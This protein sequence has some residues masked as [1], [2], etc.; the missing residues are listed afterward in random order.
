MEDQQSVSF[1]VRYPENSSRLLALLAVFFWFKILLLIPHMIILYALSIAVFFT[2]YIAQW[3][4]LFTG[5]YPRGLFDFGVGV[6]RWGLRVGAW[7][8]GWT[9]KYPPF[10]MK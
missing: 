1:E 9:D 10:G 3:V 8:N 2:N 4:I 6:Q 5:K 7:A